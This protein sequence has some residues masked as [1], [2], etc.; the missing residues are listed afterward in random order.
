MK[1][2]QLITIILLTLVSF[3]C[4]T[5]NVGLNSDNQLL[6]IEVR[7]AFNNHKTEI[8]LT[9]LANTIKYIP[10]ETNVLCLLSRVADVQFIQDY[11]LVSDTRGIFQFN[12]SGK[13]LQQIGRI[14]SG[15]GEHGN[16]IKF[17][18]DPKAN[19]VLVLNHPYS[20]N[21]YDLESGNFKRSFASQQRISNIAAFPDGYVSL[22]TEEINPMGNTSLLNEAY[23]ADRN[24]NLIDSITDYNRL[25]NNN[26]VIGAIHL[27]NSGQQPYFIGYGKDTLWALNADFSKTAYAC[28]EM[29][30]KIKWEE[31]VVTPDKFEELSDRLSI[32]SITALENNLFF[33]I[34]PGISRNPDDFSKMVFN[35]ETNELIHVKQILNDIDGGLSFWP[36][37]ISGNKKIDVLY[38]HQ[39][40]EFFG[41]TNSSNNHSREF[42]QLMNNL[43]ETDNPVLVIVE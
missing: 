25:N 42:T 40:L 38:P 21:I 17:T 5:R 11:I 18:V 24:G 1:K 15:P 31:L 3:S 20:I 19:E 39:A 33:E 35:K 2:N 34:V 30:N 22:F 8:K 23:L 26:S 6:Q 36:R 29:K 12:R 27:Y 14:G 28:F 13:F 7:N 43:S 32:Y 41:N 37:W 10:L 16:F 9:D 4:Q